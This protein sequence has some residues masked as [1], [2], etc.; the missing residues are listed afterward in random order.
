MFSKVFSP[1]ITE[2][3]SKIHKRQPNHAEQA[4]IK[5]FVKVTQKIK[6][7]N[8]PSRKRKREQLDEPAAIRR[9]P[10]LAKKQRTA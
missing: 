2:V 4:Q 8:K 9:S 3:F 1:A 6:K 10:R 5:L 7:V